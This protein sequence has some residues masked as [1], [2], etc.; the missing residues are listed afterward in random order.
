MERQQ[1][2]LKSD[3]PETIMIKNIIFDFGNVFIEWNPQRI[4]R[5]ILP[6]NELDNFMKTVWREE[7]NNN[8]DCGISF[9][10]NEKQLSAKYPQHSRYIA[11]FHAH[12]YNSLGEENRES[13]LLLSDLQKAGYSTYGLSNWSAETFSS[14]KIAH[15]FFNTLTDIVISGEEKVCKPDFKIYR[16]LLERYQLVPEECVFI[17]DR[18]ENLEPAKRLGIESV[19]FRTTQQTRDDLKKMEIL[20]A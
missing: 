17:D 8:L 5:R 15:P 16:I 13:L 9:A 18:Q 12:W 7:W 20:I 11:Y 2:L 14:T 10:D 1:K 4:F 6:E 19:L 3:V